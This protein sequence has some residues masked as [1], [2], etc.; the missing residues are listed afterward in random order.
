[1]IHFSD[2]HSWCIPWI[3]KFTAA[4]G[5][6][7]SQHLES[8]TVCKGTSKTIQNELLDIVYQ[9]A[10]T[11]IKKE[12]SKAKFV[13]AISDDTTDVSSYQQNVVVFRYIVDGKVVERFWPFG[14]CPKVMLRQYKPQCLAA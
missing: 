2:Y 1:M 3:G 8:A 4:S 7:L 9:T 5:S 11:E 12:I 13:A 14:K 6:A 10:K